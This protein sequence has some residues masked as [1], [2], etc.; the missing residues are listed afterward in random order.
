MNQFMSNLVSED[1]SSHHVL[2]KYGQE[3]AKM[4]K[5]KFHDVTLQYSIVAYYYER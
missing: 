5:R 3:N 4:E 2:L 1:V